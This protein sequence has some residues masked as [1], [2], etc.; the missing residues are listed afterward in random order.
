MSGTTLVV[1]AAIVTGVMVTL[2]SQMLGVLEVRIGT[3]AAAAVTFFTGG[4]LG[5][6]LMGLLRPD[7]SAWREAPWWAWLGGV[8]GLVLLM[9]LSYA[10]PRIGI[11]PTLSIVIATQ[12]VVA[13][14][15]EQFGLLGA[16]ERSLD[17]TRVTGLALVV[18]G[19]WLVFR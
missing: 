4:V 1:G 6:A 17:A 15:L 14:V 12:L 11:T 19:A 10:I 9:G 18:L 16:V 2:Q 3:L 13:V 7:L 5:I 8:A